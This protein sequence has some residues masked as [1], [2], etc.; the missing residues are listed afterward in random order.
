MLKVVFNR[1]GDDAERRKLL[2]DGTIL[3]Y[4]ASPASRALCMHARKMVQEAFGADDPEHAQEHM[5]IEKFVSIVGPLKSRFTNDSQTKRYV[6]DYLVEQG[7]DP[8]QTFFD[9]PRLRVGPHSEYLTAGVSYA[10]KAH[11][12]IWYSSP[13]AQVNWWLPVWDVTPERTMAFYPNYWDRAIKNSSSDFDYGEWI[14]VGRTQAT[15]QI[16]VDTRKHPLPL[17]PL[18]ESEEFRYGAAMGDAVVFSASH[19]HATVPNTSNST[20][21]SLDF[22]TVNI[23]DLK[24]SRGGLNVD[25]RSRGSTLGDFLSVDDLSVLKVPS[26]LELT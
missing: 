10:Y 1:A 15:N 18:P 22:R 26:D 12:D 9:V 4:A 16:K 3:F 17:E 23:E 8:K 14:R 2:Y 21:Y 13:R 19:L 11:R 6:C 7:V 5:P 24:K 25:S 20:R